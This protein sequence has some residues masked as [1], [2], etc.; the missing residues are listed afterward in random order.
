MPRMVA[1]PFHDDST[2]S[3]ALYPDHAYCFA[4]CGKISYAQL[5]AWIR[6]Q[7]QAGE[8]RREQTSGSPVKGV[9]TGRLLSQLALWHQVLLTD[10]GA[11]GWLSR[12]GIDLS[13]VTRYQLGHTGEHFV[14]P[15]WQ[16]SRITGVRFRRDE[17]FQPDGPKYLSP[18]GQPVLVFRPR[19]D[20]FPCV[21]V[22]GELDALLLV[23][24][25]VDAVTTTGGAGS[26][27]K[28]LGPLLRGRRIL[29]ATDQDAAG[30][31]AAQALA[32]YAQVYR[33]RW[34]GA[35]D[36][37]EL[38]APLSLPQRIA[39]VQDWIHGATQRGADPCL[40]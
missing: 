40:R 25:G 13:L 36:V 2:P 7:A 39:L 4:G 8:R 20:G 32:T 30:D 35:K 6:D 23:Q 27:A 18:A 15:V 31:A 21:V 34:Q 1:C 14:I 33:V 28:T 29:V 5:P 11:L 10:Q 3:L 9:P 16:G 22:E 17:R 12:R 37:S 19:P 26:L 38:L 24:L